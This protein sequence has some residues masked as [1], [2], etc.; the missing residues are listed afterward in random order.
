MLNQ[1][2]SRPCF[3]VRY[4]IT[5]NARRRP[6]CSSSSSSLGPFSLMTIR[7]G[8]SFK[9]DAIVARVLRPSDEMAVPLPQKIFLDGIKNTF[10]L[11]KS[12]DSVGSVSSF[13]PASH[14]PSKVTFSLPSPMYSIATICSVGKNAPLSSLIG[15]ESA[16]KASEKL[17]A[18]FSKT[19]TLKE[20]KLNSSTKNVSIRVIESQKVTIHSGAP[21]GSSSSP[22]LFVLPIIHWP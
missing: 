5:A 4:S 17:I 7:L 14:P 8:T 16:Y 10:R 1:L 13:R 9:N 22:C 6:N 3:V 2:L 11:W 15:G 21:A 18:I 19:S 20:E 12:A